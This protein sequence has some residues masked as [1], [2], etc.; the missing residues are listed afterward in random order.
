MT[1]W[2]LE[3]Y[4]ATVAA[5]LLVTVVVERLLHGR[6][7]AAVAKRQASILAFPF[8][9]IFGFFAAVIVAASVPVLWIG[10]ILAD[11]WL[12]ARMGVSGKLE[13]KT[14]ACLERLSKGYF[15]QPQH[16]G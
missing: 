8:L 9:K 12:P 3:A 16:A 1:T 2:S 15:Y 4:I 5:L 6:N 11:L 13:K 7:F 14:L 10:S